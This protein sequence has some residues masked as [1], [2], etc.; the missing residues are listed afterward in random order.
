MCAGRARLRPEGG[1]VLVAAAAATLA[2]APNENGR[3]DCASVVAFRYGLDDDADT[4]RDDE[5]EA[6][7]DRPEGPAL[8][9]WREKSVSAAA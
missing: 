5:A 4:R 8:R 6:D 3:E 9:P 7:D 2:A 1:E